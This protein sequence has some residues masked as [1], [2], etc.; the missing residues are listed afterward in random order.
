MRG[1]APMTLAYRTALYAIQPRSEDLGHGA[2]PVVGQYSLA[3]NSTEA[4]SRGG[5]RVQFR[6]VG[7]HREDSRADMASRD[8]LIKS[9]REGLIHLYEPGRLRR[10]PLAALFGVAQRFDSASAL[11]RILIEAV[12]SLEPRADEPLHSR[13]WE[14]YEPLFYRYV[15]QLSQAEVADQMRMSARHLRRKE[16]DALEALADLLCSQFSVDALPK[17]DDLGAGSTAAAPEDEEEDEAMDEGLSWLADGSRGTRTDLGLTLPGVLDLARRLADE[18][19]V[20]LEVAV[21]DGLPDVPADPVALRQCL[22]SLLTVAIP[23][24]SGGQVSFSARAVSWE[25]EMCIRCPAYPSGPKP[26]LGDEAASLNMA[27]HLAD[28]SGG[29]LALAADA[30]AFDATL[31]WPAV[32]QSPVLVID[33]NADALQLL[34]RYTLG[35]RYRFIGARDPQEALALAEEHRPRAIVLDVMMPD[36]DGWELLGRLRQHPST[37][38]IPIVVCT[39]LPQKEMARLLGASAFLKK[40]VTRQEFLA[41]LDRQVE[42][43]ETGSG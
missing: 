35:T 19:R 41:A 26:A 30:R 33:D 22:L 21:A 20:R 4:A 16:R 13:A 14:V 24:A 8:E 37:A 27:R 39:I 40:P 11:Q 7:G 36:L 17:V 42:P 18:H 6:S 38:G 10:S 29:R 34:Q 9:L 28:L 2:R 23:R 25:V 5:Y 12:K 32:E 31:T 43:A 3:Y 15:E 1:I